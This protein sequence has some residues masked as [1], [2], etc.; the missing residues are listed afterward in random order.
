MKLPVLFGQL[1]QLFTLVDNNGK[2]P[3]WYCVGEA[4]E[5]SGQQ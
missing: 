1:V 5:P 3:D 4:D 2:K